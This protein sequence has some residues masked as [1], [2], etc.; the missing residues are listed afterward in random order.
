MDR[1]ACLTDLSNSFAFLRL[2]PTRREGVS[3]QGHVTVQLFTVRQLATEPPLCRRPLGLLF[4]LVVYSDSM[5][6]SRQVDRL[7]TLPRFTALLHLHLVRPVIVALNDN[8][9]EY[10]VSTFRRGTCPSGAIVT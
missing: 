8:R 4:T 7:T 5:A 2:S 3:W 6:L 10:T 9:L 1:R